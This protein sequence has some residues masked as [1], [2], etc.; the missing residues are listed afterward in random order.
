LAIPGARGDFCRCPTLDVQE[1]FAKSTGSAEAA[2][3]FMGR[4]GRHR[5]P[6]TFARA[7]GEE[8]GDRSNAWRSIRGHRITV[9]VE[10]I[11]AIRRSRSAGGEISAITRATGLSR[12]TIDRILGED[13]KSPSGPGD[14]KPLGWMERESAPV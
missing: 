9:T 12:P 10:Q 5:N 3:E 4:E 6:F 14:G 1:V 13:R 2:R 8:K 7:R 11:T